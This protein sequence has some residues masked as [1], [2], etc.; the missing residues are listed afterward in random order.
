MYM[1]DRLHVWSANTGGYRIT[2]VIAKDPPRLLKCLYL[3]ALK[4]SRFAGSADSRVPFFRG[5]QSPVGVA[6]IGNK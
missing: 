5:L 6:I 4:L 3:F 1:Y 2:L